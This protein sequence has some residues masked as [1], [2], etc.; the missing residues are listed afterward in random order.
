MLIQTFR[1]NQMKYSESISHKE[2]AGECFD[3]EQI[4]NN[5]KISEEDF[6]DQFH[7]CELISYEIDDQ[8][9]FPTFQFS[10]DCRKF[11]FGKIVNEL[12]E[13]MYPEKIVAFL[14]TNH[15]Y[16]KSMTGYSLPIDALMNGFREEILLIAFSYDILE[17]VDGFEDPDQELLNLLSH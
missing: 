1:S 5:F 15:S 6:L 7:N 13:C 14:F 11:N 8:L 12:F 2:I 10:D 16:V 9:L 4:Q 17:C 3:K